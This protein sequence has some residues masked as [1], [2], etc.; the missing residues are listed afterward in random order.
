MTFG[1]T[2]VAC[3]GLLAECGDHAARVARYAL[4]IV[5]QSAAV[6][7]H[8]LSEASFPVRAATCTGPLEGGVAG[9]RSLRFFVTGRALSDALAALRCAPPGCVSACEPV[10]AAEAERPQPRVDTAST[11]TVVLPESDAEQA[12]AMSAWTL[13][14]DDAAVERERRAFVAT[15]E[16]NAG[17]F[18]QLLVPIAFTALMLVLVLEHSAPHPRR[19]D[20]DRAHGAPIGLGVAILTAAPVSALRI[21]GLTA[22]VPI[23]VQYAATAASLAIGCTSLIFSGCYFAAMSMGV[24]FWLGMPVLFPR[25]SW[26]AQVAAQFFPV[27]TPWLYWEWGVNEFTP[28]GGGTA[29]DASIHVLLVVVFVGY[30]YFHARLQCA[31]FAAHHTAQLAVQT[32]QRHAAQQRALLEGLLPPHVIPHI[33][34][35]VP[36][37]APLPK[38]L[39]EWRSLTVVQLA[40]APA[41]LG[42]G[43]AMPLSELTDVW[44]WLPALISDCSD[45]L[46]ELVQATSDTALVA[47]P[48][49]RGALMVTDADSVACATCAV[50]MLR[51][52]KRQLPRGIRFTAVATAGNAYGAL[53][54]A[55]HLTFRLFGAPVRE[56]DA[57]LLAAPRAPFSVAYATEGFRQQHSNF[58]VRRWTQEI[59]ES[60]MSLRVV[61]PTTDSDSVVQSTPTNEREPSGTPTDALFAASCGMWRV[62]GVGVAAMTVLRL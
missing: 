48:F 33:G 53:L 38:D 39:R 4:W 21:A 11:C 27:F 46:L 47:G 8:A 37:G 24:M 20:D 55:S 49:S 42:F 52:V 12:W 40:F 9:D 28:L 15:Q 56:S 17:R 34:A 57:L 5:D 50:T 3:A 10:T 43:A 29:A 59:G 62:R 54:G 32:A 18:T 19:Q 35:A 25:L 58:C 60:G 36:S 22:R 44:R 45:G 16:A 13:R 41:A 31:Q 23:A 1:D 61:P 51:R 30:R 2:Y 7:A 6:N 26:H 14:F